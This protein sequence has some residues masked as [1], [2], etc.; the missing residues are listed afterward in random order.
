MTSEGELQPRWGAVTAKAF[1]AGT[2]VMKVT[3]VPSLPSPVP[4]AHRPPRF[5]L[6]PN[7]LSIYWTTQKNHCWVGGREGV[8]ERTDRRDL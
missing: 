2:R 4:A 7:S 3:R 1:K 6:L 8:K 5:P